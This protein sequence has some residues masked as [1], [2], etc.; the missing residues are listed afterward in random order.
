MANEYYYSVALSILHPSIDP[1]AIT[2]MLTELHPIKEVMVGSDRR[3]SQGNTV[4]P[5]RKSLYS[6]WLADLHTE[7]RLYSGSVSMSDFIS[8]RLSELERHRGFFHELRKDGE[9]TLIVAWFC[10]TNHPADRIHADALQK[11]G[12]LGLD[13]DLYVYCNCDQQSR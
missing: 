3:D 11:C 4:T 13:V 8:M 7:E 2:T 1:K 6:H 12:D 10:E 9:V 5:S